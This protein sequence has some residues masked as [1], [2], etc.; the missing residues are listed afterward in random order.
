MKSFIFVPETV[1]VAGA[2]LRCA[3][4]NPLDRMT[5]PDFIR[6]WSSVAYLFPGLHPDGFED[7]ESG[8]PHALRRFAAEAWRRADSGELADDELY[9]CEAQWS[10]LCDRMINPTP[11]ETERRREIAALSAQCAHA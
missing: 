7:A 6:A 11:D 4:A 1:N 8:W 10:G 2:E 5:K 3:F 9:P